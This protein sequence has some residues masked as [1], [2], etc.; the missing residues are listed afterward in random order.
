MHTQACI[1]LTLAIHTGIWLV[2]NQNEYLYF[3]ST[4]K[5]KNHTD[6]SSQ[7]KD[8]CTKCMAKTTDSLMPGL[9]VYE[10]TLKRYKV[11]WNQVPAMWVETVTLTAI[12]TRVPFGLGASFVFSLEFK[13]NKAK[14]RARGG[15]VYLAWIGIFGQGGVSGCSTQ[16]GSPY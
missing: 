16:D 3:V 10:C 14:A 7:S 13:E 9:T 11:R 8:F 4:Y 12:N 15:L 5:K 6:Y 1:T 2:H